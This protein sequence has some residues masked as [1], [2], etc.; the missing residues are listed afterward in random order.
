MRDTSHILYLIISRSFPDLLARLFR[1][2]SQQPPC[3]FPFRPSESAE[4]EKI[5]SASAKKM[6][7]IINKI[8]RKI[9]LKEFI[10]TSIYQ[11][12]KYF[13]KNCILLRC[14]NCYPQ[15]PFHNPFHIPHKHALLKKPFINL[16]RIFY[17]E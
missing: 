15:T 1:C 17:P 3:Y 4:A 5:L 6:A 13:Q 10:F 12:F 9:L 14:S 2:K 8:I 7:G 11:L 16:I